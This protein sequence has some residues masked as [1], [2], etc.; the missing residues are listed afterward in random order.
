MKA[1]RLQRIKTAQETL[2]VLEQKFYKTQNEK[3]ELSDDIDFTL[4]GTQLYESETLEELYKVAHHPQFDTKVVFTNESTLNAAKR[5][6]AEEDEVLCLNFASAKNP[7]GGFLWGCTDQEESIAIASTLYSSLTS[8]KE[9][10]A[11]NKKAKTYCYTDCMIYSPAVTV[12]RD[13]DSRFLNETF[14]IN[15]LTSP[16]PKKSR[17][18]KYEAE[19]LKKIPEITQTRINKILSLCREQKQENLVLGAWGCGV[20][21][22]DPREI[23][24]QFRFALEGKFKG[25]FKQVCFAIL[26]RSPEQTTLK[27]F[28]EVFES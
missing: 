23:A 18:E 9:Y 13:E 24:K 26:D 8:K 19:N 21:K 22:N 10:Y 20:F 14:K 15:I 3:R 5:I 7:G 16:A 1:N 2:Q 27:A 17:V 25:A 28:Q 4:Q 6:L 11:I 12:F